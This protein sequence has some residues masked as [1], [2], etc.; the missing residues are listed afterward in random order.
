MEGRRS[1]AA[2]A[3]KRAGAPFNVARNPT[4]SAAQLHALARHN[5]PNV[6]AAVAGNPGARRD[7][8][9]LVLA[10]LAREGERQQAAV[11]D[12]LLGNPG[13]PV[14]L[15]LDLLLLSR[16][17]PD[18]ARVMARS[19]AL[20]P[21][22]W[23]ALAGQASWRV[24]LT[25]LRS[26]AAPP[27]AL[28][29]IG[30][31]AATALEMAHEHLADEDLLTMVEAPGVFA[32][33]SLDLS[34]NVHLT[35]DAFAALTRS[36]AFPALER[37]TV[38]GT[39]FGPLAAGALAASTSP[40]RLEWLDLRETEAGDEAAL[41][42]AQSTAFPRLRH[43][44]LSVNLEESRNSVGD[45][46]AVA[47]AQATGLGQLRLLDL[48]GG[49]VGDIGVQSLAQ[50]RAFPRLEELRLVGTCL[51]DAGLRALAVS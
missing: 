25:L 22:L 18:I 13:L 23:A 35:D 42:L 48:S 51:D 6:R 12:A 39:F 1:C 24:R 49:S 36:A 34:H 41:A 8:I 19:P 10:D 46:G 50:S 45:A 11:V 21:L 32:A 26:P 20:T 38:A 9:D 37:L 15:F 47:L 29:Q 7:T 40:R 31:H 3:M 30:L 44:D 14:W 2:H 43:L 5:N 33:T 4:S 17:P 28:A 16:Q 27:D